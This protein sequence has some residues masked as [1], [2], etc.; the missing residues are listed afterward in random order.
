MIEKQAGTCAKGAPGS[1]IPRALLAVLAIAAVVFV[2][3]SVTLF[4]DYGMADDYNFLNCGLNRSKAV[5]N[6]LITAGR[7]LNG[8]LLD[9]GFKTAG[10]IGNLAILRAITLVGIWL[11][12]CGLYFFAR[13]H[14]VG[15]ISSMAI[16]CGIVLLPSFQVYASWAQH[17]TTP[18]AAAIALFSA[19]ILTPACAQREWSR[20]L[21]ILYSTLLLTTAIVIYQPIAM[22]FCTG[23]LISIIA[24]AD[25]AGTWKPGR[26]FDAAAVFVAANTLGFLVLKTGL[27]YFG[28]P[29]ASA[30]GNLVQ[31]IPEKL[32]WF[33]SEPLANSLSLYSVP[34]NQPLEIFVAII[35]LL[36]AIFFA[37]RHPAGKVV[38]AFAY[39]IICL[40]GSYLPNL[41]TAE[42]W[43]SYRTIG[44]LGAS[45]IVLLVLMGSEIFH[46][47]RKRFPV[48]SVLGRLARYLWLVP[49]VGLFAMAIAVQSNVLNSIVLPNVTELNNL[50]S[51][52]NEE[53]GQKSGKVVVVVRLSSFTDSAVRP[54]AYDEFGIPSSS[55]RDDAKA[56][57][58][59]L[60]RNTNVSPI[61]VNTTSE[62]IDVTPRPDHV[63]TLVV[64]FPRL[65]T[66]QR[67][68]AMSLVTQH[69]DGGIIS[70]LNI[71]DDNWTA[72]IW[73][74]KHDPDVYSFVY[75]LSP[76]EPVLKPGEELNFHKSGVRTVSRVDVTGGYV[77]VRVDGTRLDA[78]DGYPHSVSRTP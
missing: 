9:F 78:E 19:Y 2:A 43:A 29:G 51:V 39:G 3:Y 47:G 55:Q 69:V 32:K 71:N 23:I 75:Q 20:G 72:G 10:S 7:P 25:N 33:V 44:A 68:R 45:A 11:L 13:R 63:D 1:T 6:L 28:Y 46:A 58:E 17:F 50:A 61:E 8:L 36:G 73:K 26:I 38:S 30:R 60:L 4:S 41:A 18:F 40:L 76:G 77:N 24:S 74:N 57:V 48:D 12:G 67:Y 65:V 66:S 21:V 70:P 31:N 22:F 27:H 5:L 64:D 53:L 35:I 34:A 14:R 52:L 59:I 37:R 15:A 49:S 56:M 62:K 54:I 42:N 16:A